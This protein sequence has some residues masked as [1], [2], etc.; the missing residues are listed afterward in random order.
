MTTGSEINFIPIKPSALELEYAD[1]HKACQR[2]YD[3]RTREAFRIPASMLAHNEAD[4]TRI[5]R[6]ALAALPIIRTALRLANLQL[7]HVDV[8]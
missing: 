3:K 7:G 4:A 1:W 2:E 5:A 6:G 8:A